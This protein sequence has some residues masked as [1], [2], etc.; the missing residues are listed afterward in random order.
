MWR[1]TQLGKRTQEMVTRLQDNWRKVREEGEALR[2]KVK[3][4]H[5]VGLVQE[6]SWNQLHFMGPAVGTNGWP[7]HEDV[8]KTAKTTC[9]IVNQLLNSDGV[10]SC[11]TCT[12]KWSI[13]DPHTRVIP[14]CG[15]TNARW[16]SH[17]LNNWPECQVI[18]IIFC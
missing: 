7:T 17:F 9:D 8:C 12:A 10:G 18:N 13:L 1:L 3:W 15:P 5:E 16:N 6:G 11:Q 2:S 14:H 4:L